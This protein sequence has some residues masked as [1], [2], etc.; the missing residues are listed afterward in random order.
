MNKTEPLLEV[1]NLK[2][3]FANG[4]VHAVDDISFSVYPGE[5]FG[6]VGES[7]CGKSTTG[8]A[9]IRLSQLTGGSI[10]FKG[11]RIAAGTGD[12]TKQLLDAVYRKD[13]EKIKMLRAEL[14]SARND[15]RNCDRLYRKRTGEKGNLS[16]K[17]Q[18]IFQDSVASL[19]PRM[20]VR[21]IVA[22][23]LRIQG[24]RNEK[25]ITE[26]VSD[27]LSTVGIRPEYADRYPHEFSG[28]QRQR[29][30]IA[31]VLI[32][33]PEL[34]IADEPIS[35]LDASIRAQII[36]L[37][38]DIKKRMNLTIIFIAHDLSVV[39]YF[40][41]RT[42]VMYRGKIL[43]TAPSAELFSHPVHPY[44]CSLLSAVPVPDPLYEKKRARILYNPDTAHDYSKEKPCMHEISEGHF[45]MCNTAESELYK[46]RRS[47]H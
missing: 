42:A 40:S 44:T 43:E 14:R 10:F 30:G 15:N 41:D 1:K 18:M 16:T 20:T 19:D 33:N 6:L 37:L 26:K 23:G 11:Q 3:Y 31:R 45:V 47:E 24:E 28:G 21:E 4:T 7:G 32:V 12:L 13:H 34:I 29:I 27:M 36:N 46:S 39:N 8:R 22:E 9:I 5:V 17:I 38:N 2:Q 35:A 25:A